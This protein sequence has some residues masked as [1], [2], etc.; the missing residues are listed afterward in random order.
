M[1]AIFTNEGHAKAFRETDFQAR[2]STSIHIVY[3]TEIEELLKL[4]LIECYETPLPLLGE[5]FGV[6]D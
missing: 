4:E 3:G 1:K 5:G 6:R 2:F